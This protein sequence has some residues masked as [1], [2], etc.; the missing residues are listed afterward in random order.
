VPDLYGF[1]SAESERSHRALR[2]ALNF[3][4]PRFVLI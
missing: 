3:S 2:V 1:A 4:F